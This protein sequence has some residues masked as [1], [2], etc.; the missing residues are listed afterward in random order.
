LSEVQGPEFERAFILSTEAEPAEDGCYYINHNQDLALLFENQADYPLYLSIFILTEQWEV[1]NLVSEK[2][3]DT[4]LV[5]CPKGESESGR[6]PLPVTMWIPP[7]LSANGKHQ[8]EDVIKLFVTKRP[9]T[10]PGYLLHQLGQDP[11]MRSSSG[12][13]QKLIHEL[14]GGLRGEDNVG[15]DWVTRSY[16]VRTCL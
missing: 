2:G 15:C 11:G 9:T 7:E 6:L 8:T 1:R 5:V 10:F 14:D 3:E 12:P 13:I 16:L 4:S